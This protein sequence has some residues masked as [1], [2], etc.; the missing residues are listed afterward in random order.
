VLRRF[1]SIAGN[2]EILER[3]F[4]ALKEERSKLIETYRQTYERH[5]E[6]REVL[7][8]ARL[9]GLMEARYPDGLSW[10]TAECNGAPFPPRIDAVCARA[11]NE[12][13]LNTAEKLERF[14]K[15]GRFR[16]RVRY[17]AASQGIKAN[18][19][20]HLALIMIAVSM[21]DR[22]AFEAYFPEFVTAFP[23]I[24]HQRQTRR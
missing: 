22:E 16:G 24:H 14:M 5:K 15:R 18:E 8:V 7:D 2:L 9:L 6:K 1:A 19:T 3:E 11:L 4:R 13:G 23:A 20:S 12:A 10:R 17:F 21:Q